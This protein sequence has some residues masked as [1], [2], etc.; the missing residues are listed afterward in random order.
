[1]TR[2]TKKQRWQ[3]NFY[4]LLHELRVAQN[5][6]QILFAFLLSL[7]FTTGFPRLSGFQ[8]GCY[9]VALLASAAAVALLISPVAFHRAVFR[10]GRKPELARY[11]HR[12]AAGGMAALLIAMVAAVLLVTDFILPG[13]VAFVLTAVTALWFLLLWVV[14]PLARRYGAETEEDAQDTDDPAY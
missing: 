14:L 13:R 7:P 1:M 5:G 10:S 3:R 2:E 9:F 8:R 11:A 4:D 12:M 6:V